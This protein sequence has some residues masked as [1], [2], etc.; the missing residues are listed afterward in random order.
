MG[1]GQTPQKD[2]AFKRIA[3]AFMVIFSKLSRRIV[4]LILALLLFFGFGIYKY[5]FNV[6]KCTDSEVTKTAREVVDQLVAESFEVSQASVRSSLSNIKT[7]SK[8]RKKCVCTATATS[9]LGV[10]GRHD[11]F[12]DYTVTP[13]SIFGEGEVYVEVSAPE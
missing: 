7:V 13:T 8:T 9:T 10:L 11:L 6:I 12:I 4:T 3:A 1:A 5:F 2:S